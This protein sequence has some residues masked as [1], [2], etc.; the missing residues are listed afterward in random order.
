MKKKIAITILVGLGLFLGSNVLGIVTYERT[1]A[2]Y[3]ISNPISFEVNEGGSWCVVESAGSALSWY[4]EFTNDDFVEFYSTDCVPISQDNNVF[5]ENL[6]IDV[7]VGVD[8]NC[9]GFDD[10]RDYS[11]RR[12]LEDAAGFPVFEVI[13][14]PPPPPPLTFIPISTN[15][16]SSALAYVGYATTGLGPLLYLVIGA[17][18]A[19]WVIRKVI[20]LVP[21]K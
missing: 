20:A 12:S 17:P 18:F 4:L 7:Y 11:W 2:G 10:C 19:F 9:C 14:L 3:T 6:P 13:E 5:I 21:K 1:P 15:F 16:V 8:L